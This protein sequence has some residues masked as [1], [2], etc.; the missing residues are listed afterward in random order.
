[1][2]G[3]GAMRLDEMAS[4]KIYAAKRRPSDNPLIVHIADV[5][6]LDKLA[7]DIDDRVKKTVKSLLAGT[8]GQ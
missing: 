6:D 4:A 5:A 3:L 7:V 1:M 8:I 2:Y